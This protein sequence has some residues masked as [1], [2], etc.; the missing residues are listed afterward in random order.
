LPPWMLLADHAGA[1]DLHRFKTLWRFRRFA[2]VE[3][4]VL[5]SGQTWITRGQNS[6]WLRLEPA[7]SAVL[8]AR[9]F[10]FLVSI[11]YLSWTA[12]LGCRVNALPD[13]SGRAALAVRCLVS[14]SWLRTMCCA[15]QCCA[16]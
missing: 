8:C 14:L 10:A 13:A 3:R 4:F 12:P 7:A 11:W 5:W 1:V 16:L 15:L 2:D 6:L 9:R